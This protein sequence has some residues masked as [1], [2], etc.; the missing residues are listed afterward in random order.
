MRTVDCS[1]LSSARRPAGVG[2]GQCGRRRASRRWP[3]I[4]GSDGKDDV[5]PPYRLYPPRRSAWFSSAFRCWLHKQALAHGNRSTFFRSGSL[6]FG[7]GHV[8]LPP[9]QAEVVPRE[10]R[11]LPR[12]L[13]R[14]ASC[15]GT[16]VYLC[17]YLGA[18]IGGWQTATLGRIAV[19]SSVLPAGHRRAPIPGR[20][21][22]DNQRTSRTQRC[23]RRRSRPS[24]RHPL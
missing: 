7:G 11:R 10:Q 5:E 1:P 21:P 14:R 6:V 9:L 8:V 13:R 17:R 18:A 3:E 19:F 23:Q 24:P 12:R 16:A 2:T 4:A 22:Q 20:N 15:A